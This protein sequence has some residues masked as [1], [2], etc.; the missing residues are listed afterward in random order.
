M[1]S[2][3][4][5]HVVGERWHRPKTVGAGIIPGWMGRIASLSIHLQLLLQVTELH[6]KKFIKSLLAAK[7]IIDQ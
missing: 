3:T 5:Q 6:N 1:F 7:H 2:L 4:G